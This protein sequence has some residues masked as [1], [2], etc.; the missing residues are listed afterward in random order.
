LGVDDEAWL[1][2][3]E[4]RHDGPMPSNISTMRPEA[5]AA[6][7]KLRHRYNLNFKDAQILLLSYGVVGARSGAVT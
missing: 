1:I 5:L 4:S 7:E 6:V 2:W 3:A